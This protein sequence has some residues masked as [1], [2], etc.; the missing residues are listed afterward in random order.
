VDRYGAFV[1]ERPAFSP[2]NAILWGAP[3]AIVVIGGVALA[4]GRRR[5][6]DPAPLSAHEEANLTEISSHL[7]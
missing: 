7:D 2:G 4:L 1:L 6:I 3:F 5:L